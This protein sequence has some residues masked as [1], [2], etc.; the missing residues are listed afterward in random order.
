MQNYLA[1]LASVLNEDADYTALRALPAGLQFPVQGFA[2][3][4][5]SNES[6]SILEFLSLHGCDLQLVLARKN[7]NLGRLAGPSQKL[8]S[9]LAFLDKAPA[10]IA[11]LTEEGEESLGQRLEAVYQDKRER[12]PATIFQGT[13]GSRE[14]RAFWESQPANAD[15]NYP[16]QVSL[17]TIIA[18]QSL[19][20][21][22]EAWLSGD[23]S[24]A[25]ANL[26]SVLF[27]LQRGDGG[28]LLF[29][30]RAYAE[31]LTFAN[32]MIGAKVQRDC[33]QGFLKAEPA[34]IDN[35][36]EKFFVGEVQVWAS[37]LSR[38]YYLLLPAYH[39]V[40]ESLQDAFPDSYKRWK[41]ARDR[42]FEQALAE[43]QKHVQALKR[44]QQGCETLSS[45]D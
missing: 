11:S 30:L 4:E 42:A 27:E 28:Q 10:C 43:S 34:Y 19:N 18:L 41:T 24:N 32:T 29:A 44:L 12:L 20:E 26:E 8:L 40:E 35:V 22:I 16:E 38:R 39:S 1:R 13:I 36:I 15:P 7:S 3:A 5:P 37:A 9:E 6:I 17:E 2:L 21:S 23:F 25:P 33:S 14:L 31:A 45:P